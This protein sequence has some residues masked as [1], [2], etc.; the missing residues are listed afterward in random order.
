L[1]IEGEDGGMAIANIEF[2]NAKEAVLVAEKLNQI[3]PKGVPD[4][5]LI[6]KVVE[7]I[8]KDLASSEN[9]V[10]LISDESKKQNIS[11]EENKSNENSSRPLDEKAVKQKLS[12]LDEAEIVDPYD[13]V[14]HYFANDGK[15]HNSAIEKLFGGKDKRLRQ[16]TSTDNERRSRIGL[17]KKD[18]PT[19]EGLAHKLWES[20][21]TGKYDT[22]DYKNAIEQV[23]LGY[24]SK[25][26]MAK[27]LV[28]KYDFDAAYQKFIDQNYPKELIDKA[29]KVTDE[30]SEEELNHLL[31]LSSDESHQKE[32]E[33]YI[34]NLPQ[35]A[36][37]K[38]INTETDAKI[39]NA[40]ISNASLHDDKN[41]GEYVAK[42]KSVLETLYPK[43]KL[44]V[45]DRPKD[46]I[47]AGGEEGTRG[48]AILDKNGEHRILLNLHQIKEDKS[49]KTAFH[50]VIHPIVYDAFGVE[51]NKLVPL[52]NE[53]ATAMENVKGFDKVMEHIAFYNRDKVAPEGVTELLTQI[54]AGN[55]DL[56][57]VPKSRANKIIDLINNLFEK[58]GIGIK[59]NSLEDFHSIA[60]K[61]KDAFETG[62]AEDLKDV[63]KGNNIDK[64]I[65]DLEKRLKDRDL[66]Q[67]QYKEKIEKLKSLGYS[68]EDIKAAFKRKGIAEEKVNEILSQTKTENDAI[69]EG[70][71]PEGNIAEHQDR[72]GGGEA[73]K[74]SGSNSSIG[75]GE[76]Q[77][78]QKEIGGEPPTPK[79][80]AEG[81]EGGSSIIHE[82]TAETRKEFGL[83]EYKKTPE[84]FAKWDAEAEQR[85]K[86]GEMPDVIKK[87]KKGL[88]PDEVEQRMM[89][90]Y[91]ANL[92]ANASADPS[93]EN[94]SKL[95]EAI[96]LS[97]RIGGSEVGKSLVA[98]K[99]THLNDESLASYMLNEMDAAKVDE[100]TPEQKAKVEKE[101]KDIQT[102]K[103]QFDDYVQK[104]EAEL[105][106]REAKVQVNKTKATTKKN[107]K[108]THDDYVK[109]REQIFTD[110]KDKLRK[111]RGQASAT[112]VPYANELIAIA[113]DVGKLVKNLL[114]DGITK[115]EDIVKNIHGK[116]K[117]DIP[118]LQ[119]K[120]VH[121]IIAGNYNK[122]KLTRNET[123]ARIRDLQTEAGLINKY[124]ALERGEEP[125]I[126]KKKV[127][128]NKTLTE[129]RKQIKEHDLTQLATY[130]SRTE[131]EVEKL[132]EQLK[133]GDFARQENKP[134]LQLDKQGLDLKDKLIKLRQ[135]REIRL[136][137]EKY[138]NRD[139]GQKITD[140][141]LEVANVPRAIMSSMDFSAPLR[142][143][144][145]PTISHPIMASKAA[146]EMFKQAGSQKAFDRWFFDIKESPRYELAK[147]SKLY[148]ADPHDPILSAKE[149]QF[150]TNLAEKIPYIGKASK[151]PFTDK[152]IG[153]LIKGSER[154]YLGY[155]NKMRWDLWNR[156]IDAF[157]KDG[158]T[159][160]NSQKLYEA[161]ADYIN[162]STGRGSLGRFDESAKILNAMF[163]SPRLIASRLKLLTNPI[164]P[165]FYARVPKAVKVQYFKDMATFIGVGLGV[166]ALAKLNGATVEDDP[167]SSDFG[168]VKV[169]DTRYDIW[170]GF[171]QYIR[172]VAQLFTGQRKTTTTGQIQ[173]LKA[174]DKAQLMFNFARGKL[175]PVPATAIDV[176]S[177][178]DIVGNEITPAS[179]A[180]SILVPMIAND[181]ADAM[182]DSGVRAIFTVGV[183]AAFGVGVQTYNRAT[184]KTDL[185]T[186]VE[187]NMDSHRIDEDTIKKV[188]DKGGEHDISKAE[189]NKYV[190]L[191]DSKIKVE[192]EKI[193]K[194]GLPVVK[195]GA[196][197][198]KPFKDV[199]ANELADEIR[200]IKSEATRES[201][202]EL[203]PVPENIKHQRSREQ[204]IM[205]HYR[206]THKEEQ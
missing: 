190:A 18:A 178:E 60:N 65:T 64:Y 141:I 57:D 72:E 61:I 166:L 122:K 27:D 177:G 149:E 99:G 86:D 171:Q 133:K 47:N 14:L 85:I 42:A 189:F 112:I 25:H 205:E 140:A 9:K 127:E 124:Q 169:G 78:G 67:E 201:K 98:R 110:I 69:K 196:I 132:K 53:I 125:K 129:L 38:P 148:L 188:D 5:V 36:E 94:L 10:N 194:D 115:L 168:K 198:V 101:W 83:G 203:F 11:T 97:D 106:E 186:L 108:K 109:E 23:L 1:N 130:K 56:T 154:A 88:Q 164:N 39:R 145:I 2:D 44:E 191:R 26:A 95:K 12:E 111:A 32:L 71:Q 50:E 41:V 58:L 199:T 170:G 77:Q 6:D 150:M 163:F 174:D 151:I 116:L 19:I 16:N 33:D 73:T 31:Q 123:V 49:G 156:A 131:A 15:I 17:I 162:A 93:N 176:I 81:E 183:P 142:Q 22:Q 4:A 34:D 63:I 126:E 192:L 175:S 118:N 167:R 137:K 35:S 90:K 8:R 92:E 114:D 202:D 165:Y 119:E 107:T 144:L 158:K 91:V 134:K 195:D 68:D 104:K 40:D 185:K 30:M 138:S 160:D 48:F 197:V 96:E 20:D 52:W 29:D 143:G 184:G 128:R 80:K 82:R 105:A 100:L 204:K 3:Y 153:G 113:P 206:K 152:K 87:L 59:L 13:K 182:K 76:K 84:T 45:Y 146:I 55:I 181:V 159:F 193:H 102:T 157:E 200:R 136:L 139:T 103:K 187:K 121:D 135:E 37:K 89:G 172:L 54:A 180:E 70:E 21:E 161:M 79:T 46:Y 74:T 173:E 7:N 66:S 155:L 43:A 28:E 51:N 120:D 147:E 62:N 75:S 179:K 117:E 24:N